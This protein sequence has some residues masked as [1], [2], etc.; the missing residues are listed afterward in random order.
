[1]KASGDA[2]LVEKILLD[3]RS[4]PIDDRLRGTLAFLERLVL[5]PASL[6]SEDARAAKAAGATSTALREASY[7]AF[8]LG[9]MDRLADAFGFEVETGRAR[10]SIATLAL[11]VGYRVTSV[12]G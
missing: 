6:T 10:R 2:G 8:V 9:V 5:D 3:Y 7:V 12:R 11:S 4:A 1:V